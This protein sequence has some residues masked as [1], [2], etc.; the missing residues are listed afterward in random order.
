MRILI[1]LFFSF[2]SLVTQ[3]Q[4]DIK[5]GEYFLSTNDPG[6]GKGVM[7]E[8]EDASWD[9]LVETIIL[10]NE[11]LLNSSSPFLLNIRLKDNNG[12]W[13]PLFKKVLFY[14]PGEAITRQ[15]K[16][17]NAEFFFGTFDP[18]EG[19][20]TPIV[21]FDGELNEAIE[22]ILRTS[23]TWE[24][25]SGPTLFNIRIMDSYNNWGP[26]FK[27]VIFPSGANPTTNLIAQGDTI[28][29]CQNSDVKLSY[30]GPNGYTLNWFNNSIDTSIVFKAAKEGFYILKATLGNSTYVDSIYVSFLT[31][32]Q[33]K[34]SPSDSILVCSSSN[35][36]LATTSLANTT[37]QWFYNG[38]TI[39][40]ASSNT[41]L[42]TQVGRY[43]VLATNSLTKC[44]GE[45]TPT[46][47][48][49]SV[50]ILPTTSITS[51]NVPVILKAP[52]GSSNKYQWRL[53]GNNITGAV[54]DTLN[55]TKSGEYTVTVSNGSCLSTS[56]KVT[57]AIT[58]TA[59]I[60][61]I[62]GSTSLCKGDSVILT[63][64]IA[65]NIRWSNG[66]LTQSVVVK[67]AGEYFV[68]FNDGNCSSIS[69][70]VTVIVNDIRPKP[71]ISANGAL[72][73][74][75]GN[76]VLLTSSSISDNL[77]SNGETTQS[78]KV[79]ES[80][81]FF[82]KVGTGNCSS[83]SDSV[84]V[85]VMPKPFV[86]S[87]KNLIY[88]EGIQTIGLSATA[89]SG[90]TLRWYGTNATGG[91]FS[92]TAPTPSTTQAGTTTYYVS[93][94]NA[95]GCES[96]RAVINFTVISKPIPPSVSNLSVCFASTAQSLTASASVGNSLRW[97]GTNATGGTA[98]GTAPTPST[99]QAG[100]FNYYVS[101]VSPTGCESDRA[102]V[103]FT[104]VSKPN[105][106][107][108]AQVFA[109]LGSNGIVL[110][111]SAGSGNT[112]RWYGTDATGGTPSSIAPIPSTNIVGNTNYYVSQVNS[113]GCESDRANI[114]VTINPLPLKPK[115]SWNGFNL[116]V[117]QIHST[118][119]WLLD[120]NQ[121]NGANSA[122]YKPLN[123]GK[124]RVR[125]TNS[126][127][128]A[129]TSNVFDLLVTAVSMPTMDGYIVRAYPNPTTSIFTLDLGK[130]PLKPYD[131]ILI[132]TDGKEV[133]GTWKVKER[134]TQMNL[135]NKP[136]GNYIIIIQNGTNK[137]SFPIIKL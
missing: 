31:A 7:F 71:S 18:G 126:F 66:K 23:A 130:N 64:S 119:Q 57:V 62:V 97:Y 79:L 63:S 125:I 38:N 98:S 110:N 70:K 83:I 27:K 51:C 90:N 17:T 122:Q 134:I 47:L 25:S 26:L 29:V 5:S 123:P 74:C 87:T 44:K 15:I 114:T 116:S 129:D 19:N 118:Y 104:V 6:E 54:S 105:L 121:I 9:E 48:F 42:P 41:Y 3:G 30:S 13:G 56:S 12:K 99:S 100:S 2:I 120:N 10:K 109:C 39:S 24:M 65:S 96:D 81:T 49:T 16:I 80:G 106:P 82:V 94:V 22:T 107:S 36:T 108:T 35:I 55:A 50:S 84:K 37:F 46:V 60:I 45:S 103:V 115:I 32:P 59:P 92:S 133:F 136:P 88:C 93:Q 43:H 78:I 128:C 72:N 20:G 101:Q 4:P 76:S 117:I 124:Y 131:L 34:I 137:I 67:E 111:A 53:N 85:V 91:S 40:G 75:S 52:T 86:P 113:I 21:S 28:K 77:W 69:E 135:K 102:I 61:N 89:D 127:Q 33:P 1:V 14:N 11:L 8:V 132:G 112:L 68:T 95:N 73:F 58:S